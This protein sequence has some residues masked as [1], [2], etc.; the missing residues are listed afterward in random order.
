MS[1]PT[2]LPSPSSSPAS[3]GLPS[4][5]DAV[6]YVP[7]SWVAVAAAVA[8]AAFFLMLAV[9]GYFSFVY[10]KPLIEPGLLA[11]PLVALVL[12]FAAR[13]AVRDSEGTRTE[14]L[15]W[16]GGFSV[17]LVAAAWWV[18]VVLGLCYFAYLFAV[19]FAINREVR[20]EVKKW[21][22]AL[23]G[24]GEED[25]ARAFWYTLPPGA[26]QDIPPND[27][28]KI[29]GR[30]RD[31]FLGFANSD[32]VRL[33][34]RNPDTFTFVPGSVT[35]TYKPGTVE[36]VVALTAQCAEGTFP[37]TVVLRGM[38]GPAGGATAGRFWTIVRPQNGGFIDSTKAT[39]TPYGW[40]IAILEQD[41]GG[42]GKA[43]VQ[44]LRGPLSSR[45]AYRG[46]IAPGGDRTVWGPLALNFNLVAQLQLVFGLQ[47]MFGLPAG[48]LEVPGYA[49]YLDKQLFRPR[50]GA[51]LPSPEMKAK[52]LRS[53]NEI[54]V[55]P[56]GERLKATPDK[57][58]VLTLTETAVEVRTPVEIP[59]FPDKPGEKVETARGLL[60]VACT[61]PGLLDLIK[62]Y[63]ESADPTKGT[64]N[65][66]DELRA[67]LLE[68]FADPREPT[69]FR[70]PW[71]VVRVESNLEPVII[72]P[73]QRGG[74]M[75]APPPPG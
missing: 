40:L 68:R 4:T 62:R 69:R 37:T 67:E 3:P 75:S 10:K 66:P 1:E 25:T 20:G 12:C 49:D 7:V 72:A 74:A 55:R 19:D 71:R 24:T 38:E 23:P 58:E 21:M 16:D 28:D 13:R 26:R 18:A 70:V 65:P 27:V 51:D 35:W 5:A 56:A 11:V 8:S 50:G 43:F 34:Q 29:R 42:F 2:R 6:P 39:R 47:F 22:D 17:N 32:L 54:G 30:F 64:I 36:C 41:G 31:E 48:V 14:V 57:D 59:L 73:S 9:F 52:F 53:W 61:D 60:V 33:A 45:F 15:S 46:F 63:K 44:H